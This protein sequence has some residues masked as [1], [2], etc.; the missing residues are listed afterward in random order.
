[1]VYEEAKALDSFDRALV[2]LEGD[3]A[4]HRIL[5]HCWGGE[6]VRHFGEQ[7][8]LCVITHLQ[9]DCCIPKIL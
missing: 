9:N 6:A 5:D 4:E 1:M 7:K 2:I 3:F 8:C